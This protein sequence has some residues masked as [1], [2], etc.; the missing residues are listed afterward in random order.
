M[1][2]L[3]QR[4]IDMPFVKKICRLPI[5]G[6]LCSYEVVVYVFFGALTTF[7]NW[8]S[9]LIMKQLFNQSTAFSNA[10]AW[11]IAVLF[12]Y[13]VNKKFVFKSSQHSIGS[14]FREFILFIAARLLSFGFDQAFMII[15]V[16]RHTAASKKR[17]NKASLESEI[18]HNLAPLVTI[19]KQKTAQSSIDRQ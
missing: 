15:T 1:E 10:F 17:Q 2:K 4:I 9:Y 3:Y 11:I 6:R 16:D 13:V 14:L 8:I 19:E 12:A 18:K 7:I 5:L